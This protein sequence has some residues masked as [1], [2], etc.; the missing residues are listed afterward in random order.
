MLNEGI[1]V[2]KNLARVIFVGQAIDHR[3]ARIGSAKTLND[4]LLE[5]YGS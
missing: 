1:D 4:F 5:G 2:G 3:H